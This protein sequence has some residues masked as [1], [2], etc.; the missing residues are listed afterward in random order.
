MAETGLI[1][2]EDR[3]LTAAEFQ[4]L[5]ELPPE[6]EWFANIKVEKTRKAYG[7]DVRQFRDF[8][9]ITQVEEFRLVTRAHVIAWRDDIMKR[10]PKPSTLRRK[11]SALSSLYRSLC[12]KNAVADN[13][14]MGVER[15]KANNNEGVTPALADWQV[16]KLL[17]TPPVEKKGKKRNPS[18]AEEPGTPYLKGVRDRAILAVFVYHA[19]RE[20][21][22]C[23]L[24]VQDYHRRTGIFHFEVN[25]KG[26][27]KRFIPVAPIAQRLLDAYLE[28]AGHRK[29]LH[30]PLFR[31][32]KNNTTGDLWKPLNPSSV[33]QDIVMFWVSS[34]SREVRSRV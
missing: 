24:Q 4:G 2:T 19:L 11:L 5:A 26:G 14:V 32:V 31:P 3:R 16:V 28:L 15:P 30:A 25:G 13:P 22:L 10:D 23:K 21:E 17:E 12:N 18:D 7:I 27:K 29:E 34:S 8:V 1:T 20:E 6:A 33:Y 9:G